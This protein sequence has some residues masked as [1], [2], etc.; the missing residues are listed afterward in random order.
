M[1]KYSIGQLQLVQHIKRHSV[2]FKMKVKIVTFVPPENANA[3]RE[4]IGKAGAGKIG[5]YNFC[6]YSMLGKGRF[7]SS[8]NANPHIGQPGAGTVVEEE[9]IEVECEKSNAKAVVEAMKSA[10]PYDQP[11]FD[12]YP[13]LELE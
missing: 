9:R 1:L 5:E 3:V 12:V 13:L 6:S 8:K 4:A 11:V 7:V 10:H 2:A